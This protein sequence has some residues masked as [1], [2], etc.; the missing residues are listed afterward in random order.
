MNLLSINRQIS[1]TNN[2]APKKELLFTGSP[3]KIAR[4]KLEELLN[5][6]IS[7]EKYC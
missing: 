3:A 2:S 1:L 7:Y 6:G 4:Y 5:K